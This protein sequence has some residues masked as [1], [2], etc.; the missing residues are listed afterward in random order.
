M[1][2]EKYSR[3]LFLVLFTAFILRG[4]A[5]FINLRSFDT[6]PD[7]YRALARNLRVYHIFGSEQTPTA[8]RPPLY[9]ASLAAFSYLSTDRPKTTSINSHRMISF[10]LSPNASVAFLHWI[11]GI[12][13]VLLVF[14]LGRRFQ[15]SP[16]LCAFAALLT[17][18]DPILLQQSRL[19]MTE[20]LA[21]FLGILLIFL[22]SKL[23]SLGPNG[24]R[25]LCLFTGG[26]ASL[27]SLG[28]PTFL[29]FGLI[30][31]ALLV[32]LELTKKAA[33][34][35]PILFLLGLTLFLLPWGYRNAQKLGRFSLTTTHG[36]YTL[37]LA[38]NDS[39]YDHQQGTAPL[40]GLWNPE[41]FQ[42]RLKK[43]L[44]QEARSKGI[45]EGSVEMELFQDQ[46]TQEKAK[47]VIKSRPKDFRRAVVWRFAHLWQPRPYKTADQE[48]KEQFL[49]RNAIGIFY[50]LEIL[51]ALFGLGKVLYGLL[52]RRL[53][54]GWLWPLALILSVQLPH[55]L[56]WTNMR[57]R[58]PIEPAIALLV[59]GLFYRVRGLA[60]EENK[61]VRQAIELSPKK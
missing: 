8:F 30:V 49:A 35:S 58:G 10:K 6:D 13:T 39:L 61:E 57:M 37:F 51:L 4:G 45:P 38:N 9:P 22:L 3:W 50:G 56:Y 34:F 1:N 23:Q 42:S 40:K 7:Q 14:L 31:F 29:A 47:E 28:R 19:I 59:A 27:A 5:L 46:W 54:Y 53:T 25:R 12:L 32:L 24:Q 26:I 41:E 17:A 21:A 55:L 44:D 16:R 36:G 2:Q 20:T 43:E 18:A 60:K 15:L 52:R 11:L 33:L 48:S